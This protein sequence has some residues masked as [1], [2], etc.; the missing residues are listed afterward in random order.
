MPT[1]KQC[2]QARGRADE[3]NDPFLCVGLLPEVPVERASAQP[4]VGVIREPFVISPENC[5]SVWLENATHRER[6]KQEIERAQRDRE[7]LMLEGNGAS[8]KRIAVEGGVS[9]VSLREH[10][11]ESTALHVLNNNIKASSVAVAV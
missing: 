6:P 4:I 10:G 5:R 1:G 2:E 9:P 3:I 7:V 11:K 8:E